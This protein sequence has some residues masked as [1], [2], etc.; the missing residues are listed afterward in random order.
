M[1]FPASIS[2]FETETLK[3]C[4]FLGVVDPCLGEL[5][6]KKWGV[7]AMRW[8]YGHEMLLRGGFL[9]QS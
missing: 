7:T 9:I 6:A 8:R 3:S 1:Q 4:A 2:D 5:H